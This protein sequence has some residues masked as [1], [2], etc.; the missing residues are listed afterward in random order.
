MKI[1]TFFTCLLSL[2]YCL[3][4]AQEDSVLTASGFYDFSLEQLMDIPISSVSLVE[5]NGFTACA[6]ID[7]ITQ[8]MIRNRGYRTIYDALMNTPGFWPIQDIN[9]K[10]IGVRGVHASTNQKFLL[11]INGKKITENLW[12]LADID[13]NIS[14]AN[15]KRIEIIRG[16]GS[17]IYGRAALSAVINI[18]TLSGKEING[19]NYHAALGNYGYKNLGFYFGMV[20]EKGDQIEVYGHNVSIDGQMFNVEASDDGAVNRVNGQEIVDRFKFPTGGLGTRFH[21][22]KWDIN[23]NTQTRFYEHP[24]TQKGAL[25]FQ[26]AES[27]DDLRNPYKSYLTGEEHNYF[28][29][30]VN[31]LFTYKKSKHA[32]TFGYTYSK[33]RLLEVSLPFRDVVIPSSF[34][35]QDSMRYRMGEAWEFSLRSI[36]YGIEYSGQTTI[37]QTSSIIWGIEAYQTSPISDRFSTNYNT[38]YDTITGNFSATPTIGGYWTENSNGILDILRTEQLYSAYSELKYKLYKFHFNLG[39]RIDLHVKGKDFRQENSETYEFQNVD[40]EADLLKAGIKKTSSQL[41]PRLA[42]VYPLLKENRLNLKAIYNRSFIAP[43]YFYRYANFAT[44]TT[45]AGGPWL[46]SETLD[47]YEVAA[48]SQY[49]RLLTKALYFVNVNRNLLV[50]DNSFAV[51]RYNNLAILSMHGVELEVHYA[52]PRLE[53]FANYSFMKGM[54]AQTDSGNEAQWIMQDQ[55][56]KNFPLH[57]GSTG[58]TARFAQNRLTATVITRWNSAISS[59]ISSGLNAGTTEKIAAAYQTNLTVRYLPTK[60]KDLDLSVSFYNLFNKEIRLG[61]TVSRPYHQAGRWFNVSLIKK[62]GI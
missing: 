22:A 23:L 1:K 34:S 20:S 44:A 14:L 38:K 41:S 43:S 40:P 8:E 45:Y 32:F 10:L 46:K 17:S 18:V 37:R 2:T 9:D 61:G 57:Y 15:V 19:I 54:R 51:P 28:V 55:S 56:I 47:N 13:Y 33:L 11:L 21:N 4:N 29:F 12:N 3:S 62:F 58:I 24:R 53:V 7:I 27:Q 52:V 35:A 31:R 48:E 39:A 50:R 25:N 30:D 6:V 36:R 49:N 59:P 5:E 26:N 16:P 60:N 42:I